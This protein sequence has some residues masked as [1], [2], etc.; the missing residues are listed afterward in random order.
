MFISGRH[1]LQVLQHLKKFPP[2]CIGRIPHNTIRRSVEQQLDAVLENM[3]HSYAVISGPPGSGKTTMMR[4]VAA[5]RT[6]FYVQLNGKIAPDVPLHATLARL[7]WGRLGIPNCTHDLRE[8]LSDCRV[9][10]IINHNKPLLMIVDIHNTVANTELHGVQ[11]MIKSLSTDNIVRG[12]LLV[13]DRQ[14]IHL[15]GDDYMHI[16]RLHDFSESDAAQ[17]LSPYVH[18]PKLVDSIL[19][20]LGTRPSH[21]AEL[22]RVLNRSVCSGT[23]ESMV[24]HHINYMITAAEKD[25]MMTRNDRAVCD[26]IPNQHQVYDYVDT[27][28]FWRT[29]T[30]SLP[31]H[32]VQFASRIHENVYSKI[33]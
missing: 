18:C 17:F 29:L 11:Q 28:A 8:T 5:H 24:K 25:V 33:K 1:T 30:I 10:K 21:L 2:T 32:V 15:A 13:T 14:A 27:D 6:G 12:V 7:V 4:Q 22:V 31:E 19:R 26:L 9:Q 16:S 3:T 23:V 20:N